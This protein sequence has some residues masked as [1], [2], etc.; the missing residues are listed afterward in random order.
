[1]ARSIGCLWNGMGGTRLGSA[2]CVP[3]VLTSF[4]TRVLNHIDRAGASRPGHSIASVDPL[5]RRSSALRDRDGGA[6][7]VDGFERGRLYGNGMRR[8]LRAVRRASELEVR[9]GIQA[10]AGAVASGGACIEIDQMH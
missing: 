10:A 5:M 8:P 2:I 7:E 4:K 1:M 6:C 3:V 9:A